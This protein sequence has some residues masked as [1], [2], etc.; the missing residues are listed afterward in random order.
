[1]INNSS[2]IVTTK[3]GSI[4][5]PNGDVLFFSIERFKRDIS[6]GDCCFLCG[7]SPSCREF[8]DEHVISKWI[9][10]EF[11]LYN[12][13]ITMPNR[14][15]YTYGRYKVPCCVSCNSFLSK[16]VESP[17]SDILK[18]G[19]TSFVQYLKNEGTGLLFRWLSLLFLKTHLKDK[20]L[21]LS[22]DQREQNENLSKLYDWESLHHIHCVA[23]SIYTNANLDED[24]IGSIFVIPA[25]TDEHYDKFDYG[26]IYLS[27]AV[28][29]RFNDIAIICVL[30]DACACYSALKD[31]L[32]S[33]INNELLPIQL[34]ELLAHTAYTK[35]RLKNLPT[36]YTNFDNNTP[37]IGAIT[38]KYFELEEHDNKILGSLMGESCIP[39]L[40]AYRLG[41]LE[42]IKQHITSGNYTF[43]FDTSGNLI[44]EPIR[45]Y[46]R[47]GS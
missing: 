17:I 14:R 42:E 36:F 39:L 44:K 7:V 23:R 20:D 35:L 45:F 34:R 10:K 9:L 2:V 41:N 33:K 5:T 8:N 15:D 26:D 46:R 47:E 29:F 27:K 40:E 38:P 13:K 16:K 19:Y 32:F 12:R 28:L 4:E 37:R 43:L 24:S 22:L 30:N 1:M 18:S 31:S 25:K 11:N 3:D 21:Y 6:E